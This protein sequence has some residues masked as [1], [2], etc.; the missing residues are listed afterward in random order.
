MDHRIK[1]H[2]RKYSDRHNFLL[3]WKDPVTARL[4]TLT[5][6]IPQSGGRKARDEAAGLAREYEKKLNEDLIPSNITWERFRTRYEDEHASGLS[7]GSVAKIGTVMNHVEEILNPT[8]LQSMTAEAISRFAAGM[9]KKGLSESTI[10]G[11]L[12]TLEAALNWG[13]GQGL[14]PKCPK[15]PTVQ[16]KKKTKNVPMK[17]RPITGEEFERML[18]STE[19]VV[20][21]E[22][23]AEWRR[24]L[25]ALWL[26][27]LRRG[28]ALQLHWDRQDRLHPVFG[29]HGRPVLRVPGELEKG[30]TDRLLPLA[31]EF[32]MMLMETP[33][34]A[35]KGP[36]LK[37]PG[38]SGRTEKRR[39]ESVGKKISEIGEKAGVKV[40][41]HPETGKVKY[42]SAH[43]LRRA[44]GERWAA[45]IMPAHLQQL[46]RHESIETTLRYYVGA[47]AE[48]TADVCWDAYERHVASRVPRQNTASP[49]AALHEDKIQQN[50]QHGTS[51]TPSRP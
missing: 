50:H 15:F 37:L 19:A 13:V 34:A 41:V 51:K 36:V 33:E 32:A 16:R 28:E 48:R 42:A 2:V 8:K 27:G 14:L 17:G 40:Q 22:A 43:D 3:Q 4:R 45:L 39:Q 12:G 21:P 38:I 11:Y 18:A 35:R 49:A 26:G 1:V 29:A 31:P 23:A 44:F 24:F 10:D 47:N 6:N 46:M 5:T 30:H 25:T 20:G 9:R 7:D